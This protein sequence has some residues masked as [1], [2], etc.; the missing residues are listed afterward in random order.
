MTP[1]L[2]GIA[3]PS[4]SGKTELARRLATALSAPILPLDCYYRPLDHLRWEER[5]QTNFDEPDAL[6]ADLLASHIA[7]LAAGQTI[8]KPVYDFARHTRAPH[9]DRIV[10]AAFV[11]VEGLFTLYW[12]AVRRSLTLAVYVDASDDVCFRRRLERDVRERGRTPQ[13]VRLQY[14]AT[15]RPMAARYILPSRVHAAV[16]VSGEA[17]LEDTSAAVLA[18]LPGARAPHP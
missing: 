5:A 12:P 11:I 3:G 13:S 9:V 4:C 10:P 2:I 8:D 17:P 18:R 16:T 1:V 15:V 14:D 6:D 7:A